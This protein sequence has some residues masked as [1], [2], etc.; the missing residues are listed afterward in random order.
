[1]EIL[2]SEN[3]EDEEMDIYLG[4]CANV[5]EGGSRLVSQSS[6]CSMRC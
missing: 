1:M 3:S 6:V 4:V 2:F 5:C